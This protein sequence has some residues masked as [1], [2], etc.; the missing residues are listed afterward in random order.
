VAAAGA[1]ATGL[2]L[3]NGAVAGRAAVRAGLAGG[4]AFLAVDLILDAVGYRVGAPGAAERATMVT[5]L[6]SGALAAAA[7]GGAVVALQLAAHSRR[8]VAPVAASAGRAQ[9]PA[10]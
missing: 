4:L 2:G 3:R 10:V 9:Q 5:V 8:Q 7:A 1:A 6:F